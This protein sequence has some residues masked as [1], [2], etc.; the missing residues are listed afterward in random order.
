MNRRYPAVLLAALLAAPAAHS[1]QPARMTEALKARLDAIGKAERTALK[2]MQDKE[3]N[4]YAQRNAAVAAMVKAYRQANSKPEAKASSAD[5]KEDAKR[6]SKEISADPAIAS[7]ESGIKAV[8]KEM[9]DK[10]AEFQAQ[11]AAAAKNP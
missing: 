4:L 10:R 2:P 9:I 8:R 3:H 5:L 1:R 6:M 11:R 7:L